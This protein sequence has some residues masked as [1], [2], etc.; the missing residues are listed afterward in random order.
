MTLAHLQFTFKTLLFLIFL[1]VST[2]A[3]PQDQPVTF[4]ERPPINLQEVPADAY[5][6][7]VIRIR[8]DESFSDRMSDFSPHRT[9]D[10]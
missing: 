4:G 3:V 10:G 5:E 7:G 9:D 6:Q 8:F 1:L 2:L